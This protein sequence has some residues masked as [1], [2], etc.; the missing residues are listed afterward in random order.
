MLLLAT[1][2]IALASERNGGDDDNKQDSAEWQDFQK[3]QSSFKRRYRTEANRMQRFQMFRKSR[4][5][6]LAH[7]DEF[8]KGLQSF[9]LELNKFADYTESERELIKGFKQLR[10]FPKSASSIS[11]EFAS[12]S[13]RVSNDE[14]KSHGW[15]C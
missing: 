11:P 3:Y 4:A 8:Q 13:S 12:S 6:V 7:N 9:R 5:L 15:L 10:Q 2:A 1:T 14:F